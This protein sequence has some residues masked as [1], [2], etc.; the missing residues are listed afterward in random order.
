[1]HTPSYKSGRNPNGHYASTRLSARPGFPEIS[2]QARHQRA[3]TLLRRAHERVRRAR[4]GGARRA[5][6]LESRQGSRTPGGEGSAPMSRFIALLT[7]TDAALLTLHIVG[8]L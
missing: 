6:G 8:W 1:M 5:R 4:P 3:Q 2:R 7:M